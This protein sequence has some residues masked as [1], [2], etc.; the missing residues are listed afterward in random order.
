MA[1]EAASDKT[2][3]VA[4]M[5]IRILTGLLLLV[6]R[7]TVRAAPADAG[8]AADVADIQSKVIGTDA[9]GPVPPN[10]RGRLTKPA[11]RAD[12]RS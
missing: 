12:P 8:V 3:V 5:A 10:K 7:T 1:A 4:A 6:F 9:R 11:P 2:K